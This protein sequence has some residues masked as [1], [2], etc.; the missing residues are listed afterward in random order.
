[1]SCAATRRGRSAGQGAASAMA[2]QGARLASYALAGAILRRLGEQ[3][4]LLL[5]ISS[6]PVLPWA[7]AVLLLIS[8]MPWKISWTD[9]PWVGRAR[10]PLV[11]LGAKVS[12][13]PGAAIWGA[14][15]P[16]LPCGML[17]GAFATATLSGGAFQGAGLMLA[18]G[19][20]AVPAMALA[21]AQTA[22]IGLVPAGFQPWI[23]K[24]LPVL[25]AV[26]LVWRALHAGEADCCATHG[27]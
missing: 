6:S 11:Q 24:G 26:V 1:M 20:G 27:S 8:V 9:L 13:A 16:L 10:Q 15:T 12:P 4:S 2:W 7:L 18:F 3:A 22:W 23:R 25:A 19:L 14:L 5:A 21:Q 17:Y